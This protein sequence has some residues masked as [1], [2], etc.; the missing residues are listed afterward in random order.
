MPFDSKAQNRKCWAMKARGENGSWDCR[1][2][3]DATNY[4]KLP[5]HKKTKEGSVIEAIAQDAAELSYAVKLA[6][7]AR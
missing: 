2:W 3:A 4:K 5:E 7:A 1:E 6:S